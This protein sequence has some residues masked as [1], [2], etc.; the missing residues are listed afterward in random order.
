[1]AL[2]LTIRMS[3][4]GKSGFVRVAEHCFSKA[5][6]LRSEVLR[7]SGYAPGFA[8]APFFNEFAIKVR[9]GSAARVIDHLESQGIIGGFD[10]GRVDAKLSDR[11]LIAVTE[12]HQRADLDRL[13]QA[14]DSFK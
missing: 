5:H 4:L 7:L 3:L 11:V 2:S 10:L 6:Y 12:M 14:L 8:D 9:G 13:I 1:M